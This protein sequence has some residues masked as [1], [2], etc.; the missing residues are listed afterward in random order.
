[1]TPEQRIGRAHRAQA[2]L[3]EFIAPM[4]DNLEAEWAERL[5]EVAN[6]ELSRDK[7][8]DKITALSHAL[9]ITKTIRDGLNEAIRDGDM[10]HQEKLR[11]S[12]IEGMTA[13]QRRLLN[14]G[15]F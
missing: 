3:D 2:A 6:T 14:I 15:A 1:M 10:A 9:K 11:A 7:R 4:F 5:V 13:P 12:R 8:A